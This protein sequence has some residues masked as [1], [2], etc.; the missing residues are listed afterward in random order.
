MHYRDICITPPP[1]DTGQYYLPGCRTYH[2]S[3]DDGVTVLHP[4]AGHTV[5]KR[6]GNLISVSVA[7]GGRERVRKTRGIR[8]IPA[9]SLIRGDIIETPWPVS[10]DAE[11]LRWLGDWQYGDIAAH[12]IASGTLPTYPPHN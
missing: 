8:E 7:F 12:E 1:E 3:R 4:V 11:R 5:S 2:V 9:A 10:Q 6:T